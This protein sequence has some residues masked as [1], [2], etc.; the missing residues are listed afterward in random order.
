[1]TQ[2]D[3]ITLGDAIPQTDG[4][5]Q[6]NLTLQATEDVTGGGTQVNTY[7]GYYTVGQQADGSWKIIYG[8]L[9]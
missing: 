3:Y 7:Q 5:V 2:H 4:T 6:V 8:Q 9:S 1:H